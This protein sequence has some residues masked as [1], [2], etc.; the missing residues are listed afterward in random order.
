MCWFNS[1]FYFSFLKFYASDPQMT[2][3]MVYHKVSDKINSRIHMQLG[4]RK[5]GDNWNTLS[6]VQHYWYQRICD[7]N[8]EVITTMVMRQNPF[9]CNL[10]GP[11]FR[12]PGFGLGRDRPIRNTTHGFL[13]DPYWHIWFLSNRLNALQFQRGT[14]TFHSPAQDWGLVGCSRLGPFYSHLIVGHS[15]LKITHFL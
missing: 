9:G 15:N 5:T 6:L 4:V 1:F 11:F 12:P 3:W 13:L 7:I 10:K 14:F 8:D 2:I